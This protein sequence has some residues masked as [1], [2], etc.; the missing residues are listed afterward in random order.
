MRDALAAVDTEQLT[1]VRSIMALEDVVSQATA[2]HRFRAILVM[3][4]AALVVLLAMAG[5][6]AA[7]SLL[8]PA[9]PATRIDPVV[10]LR[11]E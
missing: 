4:F 5:V 9:W 8:A 2:R 1:S 11:A 10:A 6:T 3:T 7:I